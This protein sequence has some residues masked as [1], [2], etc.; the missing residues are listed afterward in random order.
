M[1]INRLSWSL[2]KSKEEYLFADVPLFFVHGEGFIINSVPNQDCLALL[3]KEETANKSMSA[4]LRTTVQI[5]RWF[6]WPRYLG[7]RQLLFSLCRSLWCTKY[8]SWILHH[9]WNLLR[10]LLGSFLASAEIIRLKH[11]C[12]HANWRNHW[13]T[14]TRWPT[15]QLWSCHKCNIFVIVRRGLLA[16]NIEQLPN[17][18]ALL[19]LHSHISLCRRMYLALLADIG[20]SLTNSYPEQE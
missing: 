6:L 13:C 16:R 4:P 11:F 10:D 17:W 3:G 7:K 19:Q 14:P 9:V 12:L 15:L 8:N 5:L 1:P 2:P 18:H 20:Q